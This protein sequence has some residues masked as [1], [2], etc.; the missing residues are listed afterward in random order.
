V[1]NSTGD[2]DNPNHVAE[3]SVGQLMLPSTRRLELLYYVSNDSLQTA[4]DEQDGTTKV[5][6]GNWHGFTSSPA[7][8]HQWGVECSGPM[9]DG[10]V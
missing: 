3:T 4:M 10:N 1:L 7:S 5:N 6:D 9:A 8:T 2:L